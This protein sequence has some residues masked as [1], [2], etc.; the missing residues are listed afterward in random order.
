VS[1]VQDADLFLELAG[2]AGVFIGFGALIAVRSGGA[3][4]AEVAPMRAV[5]SMGVLA[6][7]GGLAPVTFSRYGIDGHELWALSSGLVLL[8]WV[9]ALVA[10]LRTPEYRQGWASGI[11]A[12]RTTRSVT[13]VVLGGTYVAYML[14]S[15]LV[16][17]VIVL[18]VAPEQESGLY[19]SVVELVL[20]GAAWSLLDL[21][22]AQRTA[23]SG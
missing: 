16:P 19:F 21:V 11:E 1:A 6:V 18:G 10:M 3:S 4:G 9:V 8:G 2:I 17:I 14:A 22:F 7:V 20:L 23:T 13:Q 12:N 5:V 15:F